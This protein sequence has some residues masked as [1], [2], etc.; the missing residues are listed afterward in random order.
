MDQNFEFI[1][2]EDSRFSLVWFQDDKEFIIVDREHKAVFLIDDDKKQSEVIKEM[3]VHHKK[4][5]LSFDD[6]IQM[7]NY[8]SVEQSNFV[9]DEYLGNMNLHIKWNSL[10]SLSKQIVKLKELCPEL[11][12]ISNRSMLSIAKKNPVWK[13]AS[14]PRLQAYKLIEKG[15]EM[16]LDIIS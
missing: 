15:T 10:Q 2:N 8:M 16:G 4:I 7:I 14:L 5:Y 9:K 1:L 11:E 6:C 3:L 13:F 12:A